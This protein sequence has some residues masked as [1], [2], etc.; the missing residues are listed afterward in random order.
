MESFGLV[1]LEAM[2]C[3]RPMAASRVGGLPEII[4][5]QTVYPLKPA[6]YAAHMKHFIEN[7]GVSIVGG[8]CGTTPE[9]IRRL[10]EAVSGITPAE[11]TVTA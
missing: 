5:A 7:E 1:A 9:H 2:A 6:G 4:D 10:A 11:R 8:C 3:E